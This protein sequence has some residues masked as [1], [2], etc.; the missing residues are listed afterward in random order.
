MMSLFATSHYAEVYGDELR[1]AY[2]NVLSHGQ[3]I[4]GPEVAALEERLTDFVGARCTTVANGT[5]AL[6]IALSVLDIGV[7]DEVIVPSFTWVSPVEAVVLRGAKPVFVDIHADSFLLNPDC[8]EAAITEHT[9]AI[10]AVNLFGQTADFSAINRIAEKHKIVVI[11]DAA[12]SF[13][14]CHASQRSCALTTIGTTSFFPTKPLGCFG[15]GGAL[16]TNDA[17]LHERIAQ[18]RSHGKTGPQTFTIPGVNSRLDSLQAAILLVKLKYFAQ[19]LDERK[20]IA[21]LYDEQLC[22]EVMTPVTMSQNDHIYALYTIQ[23][24]YR[25][26][27]K[28]FLTE[29]GIPTGIYYTQPIHHQLGK[30]SLE[31]R[32]DTL[33]ITDQMVTRVL[34]LPIHPFL[35]EREQEKVISMIKLFFRNLNRFK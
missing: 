3:Y 22:N 28:S 16:F 17:V 11:E 6:F 7:H 20:R 21:T 24:D 34:S 19:E 25:D 9:R 1:S 18:F 27:L 26:E 15:D 32:D 5:D 13:G 12:Q 33:P 10:I 31:D 8:I 29:R 4:L 2:E 14:A 30:A 35:Q 23:T